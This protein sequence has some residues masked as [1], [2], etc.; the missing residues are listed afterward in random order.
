MNRLDFSWPD[1]RQGA[2]TS[3]WDDGTAGDRRLV[4]ILNRNGL[5]GT[6]NLNSGRLF[7]P[8]DAPPPRRA[9]IAAEEVATLYRGH[10]VACHS[11][12]HPSLDR[13]PPEAVRAEIVADRRALESLVGYPV[14]GLALPF[15]S[16]TPAVL[17]MLRA[18]GIVYARPTGAV[19]H[20]GPPPDFMEWTP[21]CHHKANLAERWSAFR[22]Q[23]RPDKLFYLWGHSYEFDDDRNWELI[24][25]FAA[26]AGA[27]PGL[28]HATNGQIYDYISAWRALHV[29]VEMTAFRNAGCVPLWF[30]VNR[31]L[32][33]LAPGAVLCVPP[34]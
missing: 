19:A 1:G 3:S 21:T 13:L 26:E 8:P 16:H 5:K 27:E 29:S 7:R 11:A 23:T 33:G 12:T 28:W 20:F 2:V 9:A 4:D 22:A 24:E 14:K 18:C 6:F 25:Q 32:H 34:A 10:E 31:E 17:H 30:R 15:G